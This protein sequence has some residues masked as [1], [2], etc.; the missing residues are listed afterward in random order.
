MGWNSSVLLAEGLTSADMRRVIPDVFRLTKRTVT[1]DE[2][3]SSSLGQDVA[4]G[5]L[6][7]WGVLWT[8]N[9]R[10]ITFPDVLQA[11]SAKGRALALILAGVSD[12]YGFSLHVA[13]TERRRLMRSQG[14]A[15][16]QSGKPLPEEAGLDWQDAEDALFGLAKQ[17]TGL[18]ISYVEGVRLTIAT[19][20]L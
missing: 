17:L 13:G 10:V 14:A 11:A 2:A 9:V 18:D 4:L 12:I 15:V 1:W 5:E 7:G 20:D 16:E 3:S 6:P 8:P 19:L